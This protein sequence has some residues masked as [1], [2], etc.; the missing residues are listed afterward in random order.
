MK[1]FDALTRQQ[2]FDFF[3]FDPGF[4]GGVRVAAGDVNGDGYPDIVCAAGPGGGPH[5]KVFSGSN[6]ALLYSFYAYDSGFNGGINVAVGDVNGDGF[7][8]IVTGPGSRGG[9]NVKVFSGANGAQLLSF[10]AFDRGFTGGVSVAAGASARS[11]S[12]RPDLIKI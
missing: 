9:P 1:V 10:F 11:G 12:S 4:R 2:R 8:D 6:L 3:A 5:V 7:A